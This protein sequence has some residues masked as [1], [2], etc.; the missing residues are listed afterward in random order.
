M[1]VKLCLVIEIHGE[2]QI[3]KMLSTREVS[4]ELGSISESNF[5]LL[6]KKKF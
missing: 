5:T 1:T 6:G 3:D 4:T 2:T